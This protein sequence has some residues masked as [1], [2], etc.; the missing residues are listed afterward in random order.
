MKSQFTRA[1]AAFSVPISY[2]IHQ[3]QRTF[4]VR[5]KRCTDERKFENSIR[6][7]ATHVEFVFVLLQHLDRDLDARNIE[8][9]GYEAGPS[10]GK[11][12]SQLVANSFP[13]KCGIRL[14]RRKPRRRVASRT[15]DREYTYVKIRLPGAGWTRR[16]WRTRG[17]NSRRHRLPS[18][19]AN[20]AL[21]DLAGAPMT[22]CERWQTRVPEA[23]ADFIR[24][25]GTYGRP[26]LRHFTDPHFDPH[27][28]PHP[29]S[30]AA[31]PF[32]IPSC[33]LSMSREASDRSR[34]TTTSRETSLWTRA[35]LL[36]TTRTRLRT[37]V[38]FKLRSS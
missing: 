9:P 12:G 38:K 15:I 7:E 4:H 18:S 32:G 24:T 23:P 11:L 31:D 20:L 16:T 28:D 10:I 21:N 13:S 17:R 26:I 1:F 25:R 19:P 37:F 6:R 34:F 29:A 3:K 36:A 8:E 22:K 5:T 2:R 35:R 27:F 14:I 30:E 33:R